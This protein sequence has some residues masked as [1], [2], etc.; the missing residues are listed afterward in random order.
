M[1]SV[2]IIGAL[3]FLMFC[4]GQQGVLRFDLVQIERNQVV[5]KL[6]STPI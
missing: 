1:K 5:G 3:M 6:E 2:F 4:R